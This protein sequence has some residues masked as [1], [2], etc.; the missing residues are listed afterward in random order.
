MKYIITVSD[1][2][3]ESVGLAHHVDYIGVEDELPKGGVPTFVVTGGYS[4][5]TKIGYRYL[6]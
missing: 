4:T 6:G 5:G 1:G 3:N 2:Y